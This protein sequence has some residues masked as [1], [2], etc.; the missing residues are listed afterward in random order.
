MIRRHPSSTRTDTLFPSTTLFRSAEKR[1]NRKLGKQL[2]LFHI[3]DE[4]PGLVLWHPKG[5]ALWQQVEQYMR[6]VYVDGDYQ[7]IRCPQILDRKLWEKSGHWDNYKENMFTTESEKR[8]YA[9]KTMNCTGHIE[10]FKSDL[11]YYRDQ[12]GR[13]SCRESVCQ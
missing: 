7:E 13:A 6:K 8:D 11:R 9:L 12:I 2:D 3:Q 4:A 5:W 10:V 1:D